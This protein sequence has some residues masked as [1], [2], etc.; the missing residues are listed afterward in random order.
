M[1]EKREGAAVQEDGPSVRLSIPPTA[2]LSC[3]N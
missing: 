3:L 2:M 1:E